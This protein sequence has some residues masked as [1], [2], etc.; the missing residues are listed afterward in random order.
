MKKI[1]GF[2]KELALIMN[3]RSRNLRRLPLNISLYLHRTF[4]DEKITKMN[5]KYVINTFMPPFPSRAFEQLI[6]NTVAVYHHNIFP[7]SAYVALTNK[8]GFNCWHCS[9]AYREGRELSKQ[10]WVQIIKKLQDMGISIIGFTG[11]EPLWREDLED[12]IRSIDERTTTI[13]FTSGDGLTNERAKSLKEAGLFYIAISLDHYDKAQHN[14]L[15]GSNKAFDV[16]I[17]AISNSL[18]HG[19]YTAVQ[20]VA[21]KDILNTN[22]MDKYIEF[23]NELGVEEIRIVEPMPTGRLIKEKVDIFLEEPEQELIKKYHIA[24]NKNANLP[25]IASF[26]YLEDKE[27]YGCG[28]GVQ[29]IYIDPFGNLCPCDF[30]PLSFGNIRE[31]DFAIVYHRLR[32]QFGR[33]RDKCFILDNMD[34]IRSCFENDLPLGYEESVEV[35]KICSKAN[36][37]KF[38][39]KLGWQ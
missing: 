21:R 15:R 22:D 13:L 19:F 26:T 24:T 35:C 14:K 34:T 28:A 30:T 25:K 7:Y 11:G 2:K 6:K 17:E 39:K 27:L 38:Y 9:K 3:M 31:E 10:D 36:L 16:A 8:C 33:P 12:I 32:K 37:P 23:V 5:G 4:K 20:L 29:H 18:N 1:I